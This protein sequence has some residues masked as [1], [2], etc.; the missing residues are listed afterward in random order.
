[1]SNA[2][3]HVILGASGG[4]GSALAK[5]LRGSGAELVLAARDPA[6]LESIAAEVGGEAVPT[7]ALDSTQVDA[8]FTRAIAR[9]GRVDGLAVCVGSILLKP[10]H[11]TTD[12][13]F[14]RTI[15]QNLIP[16]FYAT[17]AAVRVM[18]ER[19]G[20]IVLFASAASEA[21]L[22]NHEAIGAAKAAVVGLARSTAAT[23][24][25]KRIRVN[26]LAPG[27]VRTA[28]SARITGS[29]AALAASTA[30]HPLG[31][32]GEAEDVARMAAFLL[33]PRN[34]WITGSVFGV[35]GGLA[36]LRVRG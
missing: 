14:R 36:A 33:D 23:Y 13:E 16:A 20:S 15:D 28:M 30:M 29:A 5:E 21:G 6:R 25:A 11:L 19:G 31:R 17:R 22:A 4:I 27:L 12:D 35:D 2:P 1:M 34:S 26:A 10:L 32:I 24:A 7:D 9:H 8:L 18:Q 3:V